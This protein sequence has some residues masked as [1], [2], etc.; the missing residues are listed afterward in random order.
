[1][2][3]ADFDR[4]ETEAALKLEVKTFGKSEKLSLPNREGI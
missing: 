1:M 4:A 2:L 3:E